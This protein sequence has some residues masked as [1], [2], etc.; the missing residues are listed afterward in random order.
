M[1]FTLS[2]LPMANKEPERNAS[3]HGNCALMQYDAS[4]QAN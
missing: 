4:A 2:Q 1:D 3:A